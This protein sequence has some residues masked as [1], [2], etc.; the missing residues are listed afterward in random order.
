MPTPAPAPA[1]SGQSGASGDP[2]MTAEAIR[3]AAA[4]FGNCLER[5]WPPAARRGVSRAVFTDYTAR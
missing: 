1:W 3:A 5:L 2:S 4:N